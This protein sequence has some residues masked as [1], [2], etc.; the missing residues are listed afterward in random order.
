ME[1]TP[2]NLIEYETTNGKRPI[3]EWLMDLDRT[4]AARIRLRLRRLALGNSGDTKPVGDGVSELRIF[5]GAGYRVYFAQQ[6]EAIIV[7]LCGGDKSSQP[8]DIETAKSYWADFK[9]R[10]DD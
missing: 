8:N 2:K 7:L 6:G 10:S 9:R 5:F 3:Q 4:V 1:A